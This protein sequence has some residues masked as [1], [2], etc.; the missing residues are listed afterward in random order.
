MP[1]LR[2]E[3]S[4]Y[5]QISVEQK[6][7]SARCV[8]NRFAWFKAEMKE[9]FLSY[10]VIF[11]FCREQGRRNTRRLPDQCLSP[12]YMIQLKTLPAIFVKFS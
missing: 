1:E 7:K 6:I 9:H 3:Y 10:L 12:S 5:I 2:A 8:L 11:V 4:F